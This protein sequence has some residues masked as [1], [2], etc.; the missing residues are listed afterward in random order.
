MAWDQVAEQCRRDRGVAAGGRADL[1]GA[2]DLGVGVDR[3][4]GLVAVKA[5]GGGLVPVAGLGIHR[6]DDPVGR[7]ALEDPEAA[8]AGLLDVL[9]GDGGQQRGRLGHPWVQPLAPQ[10]VVGPVGVA[11]QRVHQLLP[12]GP[13]G[14]VT[15]RLARRGVVVLAL[16]PR[17]HLGLASAGGQARSS[18]RI[19]PRSIVTVSW[20]VTASSNGA[21]SS[22][23]LTPTSPTWRASSQVTR[24][25]RSGSA[26]RRS[27]ARRSTSTVWAKLAVS[28]PA[29]ASATPAAY[30]QR[31]SKANRSAASR[32]DSPSSRCSTITTA[33]IDGGTDRRPV[34]SNR[35]ANSSGGNS[36]ARSRARNRYTDPSGSAASHQ[37]APAVGSSGR[38][39]WRPRVTAVLQVRRQGARSLPAQRITDE[40][41][42]GHRPPRTPGAVD[43]R[44]ANALGSLTP[45]RPGAFTKCS[46]FKAAATVVIS[47]DRLVGAP[48]PPLAHRPPPS[49]PSALDPSWLG[50]AGSV[51]VTAPEV[52]TSILRGHSRCARSCCPEPRRPGRAPCPGHDGGVMVTC[53]SSTMTSSRPCAGCGPP[54]AP[55][56]SLRSFA[57]TWSLA[58]SQRMI[59]EG[60][61]E[62]LGE[63]QRWRIRGG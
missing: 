40:S 34:G 51:P 26:E 32:S 30:R 57:M 43:V 31:T 16:Q 42:T 19:A 21:E 39:S 6:G 22:T 52:G 29:T 55:S 62:E 5:V 44:G 33:R 50:S 20:V 1:G 60:G 2:D 4:M 18:P 24:K 10:G 61:M 12:G 37:R 46:L 36:R 11:D 13:I 49:R 53:P 7:G 35:S 14:P 47:L 3:D 27:R 56:R 28:S 63:G 15:G 41:D 38:R 54:P 58:M 59:G 25:I 17:S 8:V 48:R 45:P 23:R 9:A